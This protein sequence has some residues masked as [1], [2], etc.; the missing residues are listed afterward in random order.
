[1]K[2]RER[3]FDDPAGATEAAAVGRSSLGELRL[4][5]ATM[6]QVAMGLRVVAAVALNE[7]RLSHGRA[8]AA[9]QRR[10]VRRAS[11]A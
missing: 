10:D 2:P 11:V 5:P 3:T 6:Q 1:M 7:R 9:A 8:T 4:N